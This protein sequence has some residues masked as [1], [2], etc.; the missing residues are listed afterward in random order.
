M[1]KY[2]TNPKNL[3]MLICTCALGISLLL[4]IGVEAYLIG[5]ICI[6]TLFIL[7][8]LS[9]MFLNITY[10]PKMMK[11]RYNIDI[12][13]SDKAYLIGVIVNSLGYLLGGLLGT[14]AL[15]LMGRL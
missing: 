4:L 9:F 14:I 6:V 2:V 8:K 10:I 12:A 3:L 11:N 5:A 1:S 13:V 15:F 7:S